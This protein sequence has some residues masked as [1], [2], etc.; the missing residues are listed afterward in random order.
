MRPARSVVSLFALLVLASPAGAQSPDFSQVDQAA[1]D[2]VNA[3]DIPGAVILVGQGD[4]ILYRKAFGSR[5]LLAAREP[6]TVET[7]FDVASLTKV[8]ATAPA[9]L[10]LAERGKLR[11]DDPLGRYL[12]EFGG[13]AHRKITLRAIL[14][15]TSGLPDLPSVEAM[16]QGLS[17]VAAAL[18]REGLQYPPGAGFRYSDTGFILLGEV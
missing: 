3:G 8:V 17:R 15:H 16:R 1:L 9:V 2:A 7:I 4:R 5:S 10:L 12:K 6:V 11:L 18:A 13:A 14:T